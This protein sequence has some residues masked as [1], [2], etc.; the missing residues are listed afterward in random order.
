MSI[1]VLNRHDARARESDY[2]RAA[3]RSAEKTM[4]ARA[5]NPDAIPKTDGEWVQMAIKPRKEWA[6]A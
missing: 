1:N 5:S 2:R 6:D 4:Q 3:R